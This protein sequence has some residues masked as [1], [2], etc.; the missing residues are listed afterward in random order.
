VTETGDPRARKESDL[1]E[2]AGII[3]MRVFLGS[4]AV[5]FVASIL[6]YALTRSRAA[7]WPPPGVPDLPSGLW[8]STAVIVAC[9]GTIHMALRAVRMGERSA[10]SR[11]LGA[12][13]GLGLLF[14]GAQA[15]NW[16]GLVAAEFTPKTNLYAFLFYMLTGLHAAHVVGGLVPLGIVTGKSLAGRYGSGWH[17]GVTYMAMYWH[18]LDVVW[19]VLFMVL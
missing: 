12:T 19:L 8:F 11:W 13:L 3:G 6:G 10:C 5:L 2:G 9:S 7:T 16:F 4:L 1:P 15:V 18:F 17:P 14:L